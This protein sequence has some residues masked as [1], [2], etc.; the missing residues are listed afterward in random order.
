MKD[1]LVIYQTSIVNP[2]PRDIN[3]QVDFWKPTFFSFKPRK[4][5]FKYAL[6]G[7]FHF[8][9]I[10]KNS[11]F[12]QVNFSVNKSEVASM[13]I[14]PAHFKYPFMKK[15]DVQFT[16]VMTKPEFRGKGYAWNMIYE[17]SKNLKGNLWYVTNKKNTSSIKLA[18]KM[19]FKL[20]AQG[21]KQGFLN[22]IQLK[23]LK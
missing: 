10:F 19:G 15:N 18:E 9:R 4:K 12:Q 3:F 2:P 22:I 6:Y 13:L 14:I 20:F 23:K 17:V 5:P 21:E 16:Y 1:N 7:L 11:F 8:I